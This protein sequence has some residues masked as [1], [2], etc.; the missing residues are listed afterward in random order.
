[1]VEFDSGGN[2]RIKLND[3]R[4]GVFALSGGKRESGLSITRA[5]EYRLSP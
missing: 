5:A 2:L 4:G 1:M 3:V